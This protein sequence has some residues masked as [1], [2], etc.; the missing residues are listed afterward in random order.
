MRLPSG[1][2]DQYIYFV[3]VDATDLKT[4]ETG[5][6]SFT[7][8]RSRN[9]AAAAAMTTP[10]INE[11]DASNMP[12]VYELLLDEDTT[13]D[14]GDDSQEI[15]YHITQ[16]SM[17][18]V[19]R[20]VEL[21]RP[22]I[23]AGYTLGVG[24]DGDL[25]EVNT[26]TGHTAQTADHTAG[27][28]D[29]PTVSEFND[30]SL[31]SDDYTVVSDLGT[32][33]TGDTYALA[34]GATGFAAI[35]T[36]VDEILA[37]T[38][39]TGVVI[40]DDA[41]TAGK[42][43][44]STA[45]PLAQA[46]SA[47]AIGNLEDMY[48][49]TGYA[50]DS[51]PSTQSQL[52]QLAVTGAAVNVPA[53]ASPNGFTIVQGTE[54][55]DEDSTQSLD[56]TRHELT[57]DGDGDLEAY[58]KFD[59]GGDGIPTSVTF[60]GVFKGG[61]DNF[62]IYANVGSSGTPS[63]AQRGTLVGS[64]SGSN[65]THTFTLFLGDKLTDLEE[66][67]IR[68]FNESLSGASFDVDQV[69]V[70]K[71]VVN[72]SIGY[73]QG[74][75]WVDTVNGVDGSEAYVNGTAD[76]PCA[77]WANVKSLVASLGIN[78]V[79]VINGSSITLDSTVDNYS[80]FGDNW[81]L[82]LGGQSIAGTHVHGAIISGVS[83]GVGASFEHCEI[84]NDVAIAP[85][86]Y[87]ECGFSTAV[88]H[89]FVTIAG[90]GEYVLVRCY[91]KVAG[92]GTP[93]FDF[94][95][96]TGTMGINNRGWFGGINYVLD[97]NCTLSHEVVG[98]GGTTV[99]PA[100]GNVEIRGLC[101][102]ITL[103]LAD[104]DV[105]NTIQLIANTGP[106]TITSAGSG[107]SATINLYGTTSGVTDGSS[108]GTTVTD[109]MVSNASINAQADTAL[110]DIN[111]DHLLKTADDDD[112]TNDSV[113]AKMAAS[114]GDW[115]GFSAATDALEA[116][117]DRGDAAWITG[118]GGTPPQ[119][120]QSTTIATLATQTSFTLTAGSADDDAYNGAIVV[121]TNQSTS[122]QKAVG[123]VSDYTGASK[124]VTL[125]AD[126]GIFTM[127]TDDGIDVIAALGSAASA[128]TAT[129]IVDEWETQSQADP[130]GFHV[131]VIEVGGTTQTANDN[132]ADI[133]TILGDTALIGDGTSGL[134]KIATDVADILT[135]TTEI[136]VAGAGL[137]STGGDGSQLTDVPWNADWDVEVQSEVA[138]ALDAAIPGTPTLDSINYRI[139]AIDVLTQ[140]AGD[141]DL[142]AI[143]S[144]TASLNDGTIS[145]LGVGVPD[146][147]PTLRD[148]VMLLYMALRNT[149]N[150]KTSYTT[151]ALE[152]SNS[153][154]TVIAHKDVSDD[155]SD[156]SES[157]M[158][159]GASV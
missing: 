158:Q 75:I 58:Y 45:F 116:L 91:S 24:S 127:A 148:A 110:S 136:G 44:Q 79:H 132:G 11:T 142:A 73:S 14:S 20:V 30:R 10:T 94:S 54:V 28:A 62:G 32:V 22:K 68:V 133:N 147:E 49:G 130:T 138:D 78:D 124:T 135:D 96:A 15:V 123:T 108:G 129:Q 13:I 157:K 72:R 42:Y 25:L 61:N 26:L 145:E 50:D 39:T 82:A 27:I 93:Y 43:D 86:E 109:S 76:K 83:T 60:T 80:F 128:P 139:K 19:T 112:V 56:G 48:D 34:N 152:V 113:I 70:S 55:N 102:A 51:A 35:D 21:Y 9:G 47:T 85:S 105:G 71:S 31:A 8:Y 156:Y 126:P 155:D 159:S 107:D 95:A 134:A 103:A 84:T 81:T 57:N 149:T 36:V 87:K 64:N 154:G 6:S 115:S 88:G 125:S 65:V 4:R 17:S 111:L 12:G 104:T 5:L 1:V 114:D 46:L 37:D 119:L 90:S 2:T 41:I 3:A 121:V 141:G 66:V 97:T 59:L 137:T 38:G 7:V 98:G 144:D 146:A 92:S 29:I 120:L 143:L 18:P 101:R 140:A 40:A 16:A 151:D 52:A 99:T 153:A 23:T 74:A 77:T 106:V 53:K 69:F 63:W 117:R 89:P 150:V 67:W 100:D 33:Q 122:T 118:A 131:N